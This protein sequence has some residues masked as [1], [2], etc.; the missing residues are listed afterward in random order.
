MPALR[1]RIAAAEAEARQPDDPKLALMRKE[2]EAL[3]Q[4]LGLIENTDFP[5]DKIGPKLHPLFKE[6]KELT[7]VALLAEVKELSAAAVE[8]AG[9]LGSGGG[10]PLSTACREALDLGYESSR[11]A[12]FFGYLLLRL[13]V[14]AAVGAANTFAELP[15]RFKDEAMA[16]TSEKLSGARQP[17][18]RPTAPTTPAAPIS[19]SAPSDHPP[20]RP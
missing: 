13:T 3:T 20:A 10:A 1:A 6:I 9:P 18:S 7:S 17:P 19:S 14:A 4:K 2:H 11:R 16:V 15:Q 12:I 5:N 8:A